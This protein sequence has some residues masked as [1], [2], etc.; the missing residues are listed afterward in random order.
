MATHHGEVTPTRAKRQ[1]SD[2]HTTWATTKLTREMLVSSSNKLHNT[3]RRWVTKSIARSRQPLPMYHLQKAKAK[4]TQSQYAPIGKPV[5]ASTDQGS[6]REALMCIWGYA[7]TSS[8]EYSV[9][10][11]KAIPE[12]Y[13]SCTCTT[14]TQILKCP[15]NLTMISPEPQRASRLSSDPWTD[16]VI[17]AGKFQRSRH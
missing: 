10:P 14:I 7:Y 8:Q 11:L 6:A 9:N 4:D 3:I 12:G 16:W 17:T 13:S 2:R 15:F 5:M 1:S